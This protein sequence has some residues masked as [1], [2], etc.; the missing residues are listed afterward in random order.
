MIGDAQRTGA[1]SRAAS[2]SALKSSVDNWTQR[3]IPGVQAAKDAYAQGSVPINTMEVGQQIAN[4]LG[5]RAMNAG[6]APEIQMMPFRSALTKATNSG[7]A[8]KYGIDANALQSLQGIGQDLQRATV[9]N[10]IKSPG[11]DTAYNLAANGWLARQL[12][13]PTFGGAGNLGKAAGAIGAAA[14]GHPMVGLGILGGGNKVGQMV[15]NRLQDRLTGLLMN[16]DTVLPYLDARAAA[17]AQPVPGSLVQGL[18]NYGRPAAVNGLLGG[19]QNSG[20]Q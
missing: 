10:S 6:G 8:A 14:L 20:N 5:T 2:L 16:P 12:Y 9:S 18:L 19:R 7:D 17:T 13:G 3:Y 1:T 15:G 4:G 11:S